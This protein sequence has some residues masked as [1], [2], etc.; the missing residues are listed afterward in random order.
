MIA[1]LRDRELRGKKKK[2]NNSPT[3]I[4]E[5]NTE[6]GAEN[7]RVELNLTCWKMVLLG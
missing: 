3:T 4:P 5:E 1:V 7:D 6:Y 2:K